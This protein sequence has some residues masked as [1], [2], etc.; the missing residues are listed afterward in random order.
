MLFSKVKINSVINYASVTLFAKFVHQV[1][2]TS[3]SVD[4]AIN[5]ITEKVF[6]FSL[7]TNLFNDAFTYVHTI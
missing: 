4:Y 5:P 3:F 6:V 1:W 2:F 7:L